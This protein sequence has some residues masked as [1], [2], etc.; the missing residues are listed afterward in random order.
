MTRAVLVALVAALVLTAIGCGRSSSRTS[1][2]TQR[3]LTDLHSIAQLQTAFKTASGEPRL[4][5]L[6]SPT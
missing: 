2:T 5:V 3:T 4:V 6:V 1:S